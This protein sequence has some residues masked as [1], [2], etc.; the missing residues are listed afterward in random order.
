M[1]QVRRDHGIT[2]EDRQEQVCLASEVFHKYGLEIRTMIQF[3]IEDQ[4]EAED[5]FQNLFLQFVAR[6]LPPDVRS[7]KRYL[8]KTIVNGVITQARRDE[9][10][11]KHIRVYALCPGYPGVEE[12]GPPDYLMRAEQIEQI[13]Q[14]AQSLKPT[15]A[16]A[17]M[18][19]YGQDRPRDLVSRQMGIRRRSVATYLWRGLKSLR[20]IARAN[21]S[22]QAFL[23]N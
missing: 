12:E 22:R 10:Y 9:C 15:E 5:F 8:H 1:E 4:T 23:L 19:E 2:N 16:E 14:T 17:L 7:M 13:F 18:S 6:P 20:L 21:E 3:A 11:R